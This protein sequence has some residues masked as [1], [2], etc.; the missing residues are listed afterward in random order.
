MANL[1]E[2]VLKAKDGGVSQALSGASRAFGFFGNTAATALGFLTG[3]L[4][5]GALDNIAKLG[6]QA[7]GM[8]MEFEESTAVLGVA[9][10]GWGKDVEELRKIAMAVGEDTRLLGVTSSGA[11]DAMLELAKAGIELGPA[12]GNLNGYMEEGQEL[13]GA[14]GAA[15]R[16]AAASELDMVEATELG[17]ALLSNFGQ[18]ARDAGLS[19]EYLTDAL[20]S[21]V[22]TADASVS[23]VTELRDSLSSVGPTASGLGIPLDDVNV[24]LAQLSNAGIRGAT[25]GTALR[26]MLNSF[27]R[28]TGPAKEAWAELGM[29][30]YDAQGAMRPL[31]D[32]FEEMRT[33]MAGMTEEQRNLIIKNTAG[34]YGQKAM[35]P[36]LKAGAKGWEEMA[37]KI[38][39]RRLGLWSIQ[40]PA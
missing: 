19:G 34:I 4:M 30:I 8:A 33:K 13:G 38:L 10:R 27:I 18:E 32:I 1:I 26:S 39:L 11:A 36:L 15:I 9:A 37:G 5:K 16:T 17:V 24:A 21:L 25:A 40:R 7:L 3:T 35:I 31:P 20:D 28:D 2:V 29:S 23:S 6:K 12:L 22:R 14:L